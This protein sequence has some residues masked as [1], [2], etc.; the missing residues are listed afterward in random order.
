VVREMDPQLALFAVGSLEGFMGERVA[1]RRF[2]MTLLVTFSCVAVL[3]AAVGLYG[4]IAYGVT[5]RRSEIGIRMALGATA[6]SVRRMIVRDGLTLA[7]AGVGA[8]VIAALAG[9]RLI[10][11]MLFGVSGSDPL[12][13]LGVT[14]LMLGTALLASWIPGRRAA[15]IDPIVSL[16]SD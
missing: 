8:G 1:A 3:M 6:G 16:R 5:V 15:S 10:E 11:G 7:A 9:A 2:A 14:A 13:L 4:V 12:V